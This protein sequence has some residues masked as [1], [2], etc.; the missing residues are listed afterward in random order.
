[1]NKFVLRI[2]KFSLV[3]L[4]SLMGCSIFPNNDLV[5][6]SEYTPTPIADSIA[7]TVTIQPGVIPP[8]P[9]PVIEGCLDTA[10][11]DGPPPIADA[12]QFLLLQNDA[13]PRLLYLLNIANGVKA[14]IPVSKPYSIFVSPDHL[15]FAYVQFTEQ[16]S[17]ETVVVRNG[18]NE[19]VKTFMLPSLS[20]FWGW[21]DNGHIMI[22]T[23]KVPDTTDPYLL[24]VRSILD[25]S[26]REFSDQKSYQD[27]DNIS[28]LGW[29]YNRVVYDPTLN[30]AIYPSDNGR[31]V[32][33]YDITL[34]KKMAVIYTQV[35]F[36]SSPVWSPYGDLV[37][38]AGNS[39]QEESSNSEASQNE[40]FVVD[41]RGQII[42]LTNF[43]EQY[44]EGEIGNISWS[45]NGKYLAFWAR[46]GSNINERLM[47]LNLD[48]KQ[49][50]D[51]CLTGLSND[52]SYVS[53]L[54]PIWSPD[55][56]VVMINHR[57]SAEDPT[58]VIWI[59]I[60]NDIVGIMHDIGLLWGWLIAQ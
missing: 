17:A 58:D 48:T 56:R 6:S 33:I 55:S 2:N 15:R 57:E 59:D 3:I 36:I 35:A 50:R 18:N 5:A 11:T 21:L 26:S 53:E 23:K 1:M 25:D 39:E 31:A 9:E 42:L 43:S 47:V 38:L 46:T 19:V 37:A 8:M 13:E 10:T 22:T 41:N 54:S 51:Y 29:Q 44:Q 4:L 40:L 20:F 12:N 16:G 60:Q 49:V 52:G 7:S 24:V 45:P 27:F 28:N 34:Q 32:T 14:D 30:Y